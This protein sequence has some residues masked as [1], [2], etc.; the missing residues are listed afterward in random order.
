MA[1][2]LGVGAAVENLNLEQKTKLKKAVKEATDSIVRVEAEQDF[3]REVVKKVADDL[4]I[5]KKLINKL[6]KV[7]H[8]SNFDEEKLLHEQFEKL[9]QSIMSS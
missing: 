1:M 2:K 8:K 5:P 6:I 4:K 9:Y 7:H 3:I